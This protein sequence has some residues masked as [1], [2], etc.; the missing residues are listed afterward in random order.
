MV[1]KLDA[2]LVLATCQQFNFNQ[3]RA[4]HAAYHT[5]GQT[6]FLGIQVRTC[7]DVH[8]SVAEVAPKPIDQRRFQRIGLLFEQRPV[9]F[10]HAAFAKLLR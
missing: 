5:V 3:N 8:S 6:S 9:A 1:R 10:P 4:G 2:N 7:G